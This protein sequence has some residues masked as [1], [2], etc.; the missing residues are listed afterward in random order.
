MSQ[1]IIFFNKNKADYSNANVTATASQG[2]DYASYVLNR[3]N[4]SAWVTTGSVD[5]DNTTL[6]IDFVDERALTDILL[7]KHNFKAY[8]VKYWDGATYVDFPTVISETNNST[9]TTHHTFASTSTTKVQITITGTM[10]ADEDKYLFQ[11]I[12]T[13][14][15][16][17]LS[18]WPVIKSPEVSRNRKVLKMLS[19]KALVK[20]SIGFFRCKLEI[21][22][23]STDADL[24][25]IE[26]LF[27]ANEGFLVWI[28]GGDEDQFRSERIGYRL[29]DI[30]LMKCVNEWKPELYKGLYQAGMKISLDLNEVV[31]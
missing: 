31:D 16:G 12:A 27:S 13:T 10:T 24:T 8:T 15:L 9:E 19:G 4:Q 22:I 17:Q 18:S 29:E 2:S 20:E 23:L 1:Q 3:S 25:I 14:Q 5:S 11:F 30:H 28:C 26:N 7:V 21:K 6:T